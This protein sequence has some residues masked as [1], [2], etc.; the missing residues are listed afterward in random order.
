MDI[1][2][3]AHVSASGGLNNAIVNAQKI[4]ANCL[5][6]FSSAPQQWQGSRRT[7]AE[8][9][10]F[11]EAVRSANLLP[12]FIHGSYLMN[13][14]SDNPQTLQ[15][16]I[17]CLI[18][19]L[20]FAGDTGAQ[21]VI[22]HFG[23]HVSGWTG[24]KKKLIPI[25]QMI[26]AMTPK[27]TQIVIENAAGSGKKI[28]SK[29]EELALMRDDMNSRRIK[30]CLDS[31]HAFASGFDLSNEKG[32]DTLVTQVQNILGWEEV[33]AVHLNDSKAALGSGVDRHENIG[34]GE[35]GAR[36][37]KAFVTHQLV[38]DKPLI[39]EV[40][41]FTDMGPDSENIDLVKKFFK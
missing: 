17:D 38:R 33:V 12:V 2:I 34:A 31:A 30:F 41:G 19:D 22:F 5:Q 14:A 37:L 28:G 35:I 39:L 11:R 29:L 6:I 3:G 36:G 24:K 9:F 27:D 20:Q 1:R 10:M 7:E 23:S 4:G 25:L 26:L 8:K 18:A 13:F 15:K 32:V 16:S 21:G 40:P